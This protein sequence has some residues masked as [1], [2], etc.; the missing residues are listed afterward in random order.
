MFTDRFI[1]LPIK[2]YSQSH[3]ELT[4]NKELEDAIARINPMEICEYFSVYEDNQD[5][6]NVYL[7][8]G[9]YFVCYLPIE[10]FEQ[11]LNEWQKTNQ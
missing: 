9:H 10:D 8:S 7:N 1:P 2:T 5:A 6:V 11:K 3:E 4:G